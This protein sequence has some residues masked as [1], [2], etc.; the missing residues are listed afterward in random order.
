L[1]VCIYIYLCTCTILYRFCSK[2]SSRYPVRKYYL[3][4]RS[5]R[6]TRT[7]P[8]THNIITPRERLSLSFFPS[9]RLLIRRLYVCI[10]SA[11]HLIYMAR[12]TTSTNRESSLSRPPYYCS[13]ATRNKCAPAAANTPL[14]FFV[15][16]TPRR[17]HTTPRL[18]ILSPFSAGRCFLLV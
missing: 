4:E 16:P 9:P 14:D 6:Y 1:C 10:I 11:I 18:G 3:K 13:R 8:Y 12:P 5:S 7:E 15:F 2:S 17:T